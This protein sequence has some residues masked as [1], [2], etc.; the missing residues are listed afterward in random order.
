MVRPSG[1]KILKMNDLRAKYSGIRSY[2][3][4]Q[5]RSA[6]GLRRADW[7]SLRACSELALPGILSKGCSSQEMTFL[8][9]KVVEKERDEVGVSAKSMYANVKRAPP[10]T[11]A[12]PIGQQVS[13][14]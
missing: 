8:L 9:W 7:K 14:G 6:D 5:S 10:A 3:R 1:D 12:T 13:P 4:S 11:I 2:L